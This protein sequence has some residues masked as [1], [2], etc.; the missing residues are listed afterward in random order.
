M[1]IKVPFYYMANVIM[2]RKR[3]SESVMVQDKVTIEIKEFR[4]EDIPVAFRVENDDLPFELRT[5]DKEILF[6]GKKLWTLDFEKIKNEDNRTVGIEAVYIDTVKKKTESGGENHKW[7]CST[8]DAPF[9]GFWHSAKCAMERYDE[10]LKTKKELLKQ[11][12]KW[13]DDNRKE[14]LKK[15]EQKLEVL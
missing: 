8:V 10:K 6:D 12:R 11:C 1:K 5:L 9:Y 7:S 2:P 3:K 14:V 4:K 15:S 13:V